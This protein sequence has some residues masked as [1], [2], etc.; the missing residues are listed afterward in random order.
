LKT[1]HIIQFTDDG[2]HTIAIPE[3]N[4]TYHSKHGAIQESMHV[5]IKEGLQFLL[6]NLNAKAETINILE[7]GFGTGLNAWLSLNEAIKHNQKMFYQTIEPYPL[8]IDKAEKL[9]YPSIFN[10]DFEKYFLNLHTCE[11]NKEILIHP[12]FL[13]EKLAA[14]LQ[15]FTTNKK[16]HLIYFDAFDPN[17]QP[18]LW[19]EQIFIKLFKMLLN[20]GILVTYSSKGIV[21]RAM[22]AAGF[23]V[24][25]LKGPPGKREII[26][27]I[28]VE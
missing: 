16:F 5:F 18:E 17:V 7:V 15:S 3:L 19:A 21:R 1:S 28:K 2:S 13:F 20:N 8:S 24:E 10:T 23:S 6:K 25:K 9:N 11:W 4:V 26:R 27:A 22:L 12:L 14:S